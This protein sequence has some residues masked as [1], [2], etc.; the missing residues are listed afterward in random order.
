V[1]APNQRFL[2]ARDGGALLGCVGLELYGEAALLR[3]L[4]VAERSRGVG[5]GAAL[6]DAALEDARRRGVRSLYLLTTTAEGFFARRGFER[7]AR[8]EV[9]EAVRGS[10]EFGALCPASAACMARHIA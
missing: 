8:D 9:P 1:G 2:V 3:S 5:L 10:A 7:I 4:A 6:A